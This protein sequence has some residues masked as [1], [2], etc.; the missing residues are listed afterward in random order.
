ENILTSIQVKMEDASWIKRKMFHYFVDVAARVSSSQLAHR[1]V[2]PWLRLLHAL[3][4]FL[5]YGPLRD[6]L[7]MG[8]IRY[9]Y[10]AGAAL[11]PEVF[12]FYRS[13][14]VNLKQVYGLT[15]SSAMC[16][17]QPDE[18]V[19]LDTVGIPASYL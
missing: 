15:E 18:D 13:I 7:G 10:T 9:A 14:G 12:Q 3:G 17:F 6:N 4:E 2:P 1:K 16:T 5:V 11:G 8:K 19:K